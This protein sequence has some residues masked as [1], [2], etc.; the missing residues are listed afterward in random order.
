MRERRLL[1]FEH[2]GTG[3]GCDVGSGV[4]T[5]VSVGSGAGAGVVVGSGAGAGVAVGS[6]AGSTGP[7]SLTTGQPD[8][9]SR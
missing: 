8:E 5:G 7:S 4:G 1:F 3:A 6:G 2:V 9:K